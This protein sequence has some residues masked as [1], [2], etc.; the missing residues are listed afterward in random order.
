MTLARWIEKLFL[1]EDQREDK[2]RQIAMA[3]ST[4]LNHTQA[5]QSGARLVQHMSGV[6]QIVAESQH[7]KK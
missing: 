4:T 3:R 7:A 1:G 2:D 5:V 6:L